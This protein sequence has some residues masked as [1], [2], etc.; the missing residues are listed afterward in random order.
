MFFGIKNCAPKQA[1][2]EQIFTARNII[3]KLKRQNKLEAQNLIDVH[4]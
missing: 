3:Y 1:I 2:E 4:G